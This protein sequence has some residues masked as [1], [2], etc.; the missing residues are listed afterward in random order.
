M[1]KPQPNIAG[2]YAMFNITMVF[3]ISIGTKQ[4]LLMVSYVAPVT[5]YYTIIYKSSTVYCIT[6]FLVFFLHNFFLYLLA[7]RRRASTRQAAFS[8]LVLNNGRQR[9]PY[10]KESTM[11][12][13]GYLWESL[14]LPFLSHFFK[15]HQLGLSCGNPRKLV[16]LNSP[17]ARNDDIAP[18]KAKTIRSV[19]RITLTIRCKRSFHL[20]SYSLL[21]NLGCILDLIKVKL[22]K[23]WSTIY[24]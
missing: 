18:A 22:Y 19:G 16:L 5:I 20:Y 17:I 8:Y 21:P 14:S 24:I 12:W 7:R 2:H 23:V 1:L 15:S 3:S 13:A 11:E 9:R 10:R 6:I 4:S